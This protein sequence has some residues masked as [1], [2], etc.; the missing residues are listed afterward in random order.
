MIFTTGAIKEI[1][2]D[3]VRIS[4]EGAY[5]EIVLNVQAGAYI[6]NAEDGAQIGL[7]D[8]K[9]GDKVTA[10]YGPAVTKSIPPQGNAIAL[11]VGTPKTGSAGMYMQVAQLEK[12]QDSSIKALCTNADRIVTISPD[13]FAQ[14]AD[15]KEGSELIVW[16]DIMTMSMPAQAKATKVVLLPAKADIK[17]HTGAGT[18]VLNGKELALSEQDIIKTD[19]GAVMLPLSVIAEGLGYDIVWNGENR[20]V[21]LQNGACTMATLTIGSKTY[22]KLKMA[23]LLERAP[24]IINGKTLVPVEFFTDVLDLKVDINNSHI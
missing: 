16:Y 21:D 11:L 20:T 8:L 10:Y 1:N 24:E 12:N 4:G 18:I 23:V 5:R 9:K 6:L 2:Q 17:V 22:G 15:I 13:V 3:Q 19:G 7:Q 14:T